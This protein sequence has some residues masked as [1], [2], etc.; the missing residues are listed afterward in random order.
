[1]FSQSDKAENVSNIEATADTQEVA[2]PCETVGS[3]IQERDRTLADQD[4]HV[5]CHSTAR[6]S[7]CGTTAN[8]NTVTPKVFLLELPIHLLR[9][10]W[11]NYLYI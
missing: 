4:L 10:F 9:Y 3:S 2:R 5:P 1:M 8:S 6:T 11:Y 7:L